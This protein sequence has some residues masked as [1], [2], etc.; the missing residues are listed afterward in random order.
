MIKVCKH[1]FK[2]DENDVVDMPEG[3]EV[4]SALH[5][6]LD[7]MILVLR[8]ETSVVV[9]VETPTPEVTPEVTNA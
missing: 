3:F 4:V 7:G 2:K 1:L 5:A 9:P 8:G 6:S